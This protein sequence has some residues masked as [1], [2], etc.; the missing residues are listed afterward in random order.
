MIYPP[1]LPAPHPLMFKTNE[2]YL[3]ARNQWLQQMDERRGRVKTDLAIHIVV[4]L[5]LVAGAAIAMVTLL[6]ITF[7]WQGPAVATMCAG[8]F[9]AAVIS[10]KRHL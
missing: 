1:I 5:V 2:E 4:G 6:Y 9:W 8:L 10:V 3:A 7:G